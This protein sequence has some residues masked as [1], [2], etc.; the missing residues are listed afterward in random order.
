MQPSKE[1]IFAGTTRPAT[2]LFRF[3]TRSFFL[4]PLNNPVWPF[5]GILT[6][7]FI[8]EGTFKK[9]HALLLTYVFPLLNLFLGNPFRH[10]EGAAPSLFERLPLSRNARFKA[11]TAASALY[12][13]LVTLYCFYLLRGFGPVQ[14]FAPDAYT[15]TVVSPE[16]DTLVLMTGTV[17]NYIYGERPSFKS[18]TVLIGQSVIF[19]GLI[20]INGFILM[21]ACL[22]LFLLGITLLLHYRR[23]VFLPPPPHWQTPLISLPFALYLLPGI[24]VFVD[25]FL[26][27]HAVSMALRFVPNHSAELF[28]AISAMAAINF[29]ILTWLLITTF[30]ENRRA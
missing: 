24:L 16:G 26:T 19:D 7:Y 2:A 3:L 15:H 12:L 9:E 6:A 20:R 11:F 28:L 27:E 5:L 29:F 8:W 13:F 22:Y 17:P 30:I 14:Y 1:I 10:S 4:H 18:L 21:A 25:P 23:S